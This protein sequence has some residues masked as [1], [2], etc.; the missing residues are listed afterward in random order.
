MIAD[1]ATTPANYYPI[2]IKT[3]FVGD[4]KLGGMDEPDTNVLSWNMQPNWSDNLVFVDPTDFNALTDLDK[5]VVQ[6]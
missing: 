6:S 5:A 2:P 3:L 1:N 4:K